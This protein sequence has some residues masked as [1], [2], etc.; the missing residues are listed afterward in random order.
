[1]YMWLRGGGGGGG[2]GGMYCSNF[3][4]IHIGIPSSYTFGLSVLNL[5]YLT[6]KGLKY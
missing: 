5:F 3:L 2:G 4:W 1:M 6:N